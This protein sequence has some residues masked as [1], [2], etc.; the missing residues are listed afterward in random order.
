[1]RGPRAL[2]PPLPPGE[3]GIGCSP[4]T[5]LLKSGSR[6]LSLLE[7]FRLLGA[8]VVTVL[9]DGS[10]MIKVEVKPLRMCLALSLLT[11]SQELGEAAQYCQLCGDLA[12]SV[13]RA[14][15]PCPAAFQQGWGVGVGLTEERW[16]EIPAP[17]ALMYKLVYLA[18]VCQE[19]FK[20]AGSSPTPSLVL[21]GEGRFKKILYTMASGADL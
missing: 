7:T 3:R 17:T 16:L 21:P 11:V 6:L 5:L 1:M 2:A 19:A 14:V 12:A 9:S 10:S 20:E 4:G 13:A 8:S 15:K 18:S